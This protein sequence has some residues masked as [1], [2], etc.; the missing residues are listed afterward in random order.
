MDISCSM[1]ALEK[2]LVRMLNTASSKDLGTLEMIGPKRVQLIIANREM[3][4]FENVNELT[5][6]GFSDKNINDFRKRCKLCR[7]LS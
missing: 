3:A 1:A 4:P 6:I 5:R 2:E 7:M